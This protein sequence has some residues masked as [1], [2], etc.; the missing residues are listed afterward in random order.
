MW[1]WAHNEDGSW[2]QD[3]MINF[4]RNGEWKGGFNVFTG[5]SNR[6][7]G[8]TG[9]CVTAANCPT[10]AFTPKEG[11]DEGRDIQ[12]VTEAGTVPMFVPAVGWRMGYSPNINRPGT[13]ARYHCNQPQ[14]ITLE[15]N[16]WTKHQT[17]A[18]SMWTDGAF[19]RNSAVSWAEW[20]GNGHPVR[21]IK[22][23]VVMDEE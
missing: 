6:T 9:E 18:A 12:P 15:G 5:Q 1:P 13:C 21:C 10:G 11:L 19:Y 8:A 22:P 3:E 23:V 2:K 17:M 14:N 4:L 16:T 7:E 20:M